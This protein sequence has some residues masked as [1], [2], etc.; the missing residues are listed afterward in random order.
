MRNVAGVSLPYVFFIEDDICRVPFS[1]SLKC[2]IKQR[3]KLGILGCNLSYDEPNLWCARLC[4]SRRILPIWT[5][6]SLGF[7]FVPILLNLFILSN[8]HSTPN[9]DH[10]CNSSTIQNPSICT[11]WFMQV[12]GKIYWIKSCLPLS[13]RAEHHSFKTKHDVYLSF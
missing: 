10:C 12:N 9:N 7:S 3:C 4:S 6:V 5:E 2:N 1:S 13:D 11:W 8:G